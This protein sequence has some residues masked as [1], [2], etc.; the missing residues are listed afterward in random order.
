MADGVSIVS[1][2]AKHL[3]SIVSLLAAQLEEHDISTPGDA[4]RDVARAVIDDPSHGFISLALTHDAIA[5]LAYAAAHLSAEHGGTIGWLEELY[6]T[7]GYRG[8][9]IGSELLDNVIS[10][11][12][13]R[14]WRGV[15]LEVV[16]GHERA[17]SLYLRHGFAALP[18]ARYSCIFT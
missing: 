4:L 12:C 8:R 5:G 16:A 13:A 3:E 7:P 11:A 6:V 2:E 15:E 9:G 18:R 10:R 14:G 17:A 1:A